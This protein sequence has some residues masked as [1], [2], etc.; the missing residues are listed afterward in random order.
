MAWGERLMM[1]LRIVHTTEFEYDGRATASYNQ[2]RLTP[3]TDADQIVSH[4]RLDVQ[5]TPW[6]YTYTDYFGTQITA[7]EVL[8]PHDSLQVTS[9]STVHTNRQELPDA[10][11]SWEEVADSSVSDRW[12]E[13]LAHSPV[14]APTDDLRE[15]CVQLRS[16]SARPGDAARALCALVY[17]K[18]EYRSGSTSVKSSG[19][20]AWEQRS[21]VCQ[22]MAHVVIGGLRT[23]GIPARYISGYL[24]P[25]REPEI[26]DTVRGESHA[27]VEWWDDG[28]HAFDPTNDKVPGD[29]YVVITAGRDYTDVKPLSGI[30]TGA[31]TERIQVDVHI[32]RLA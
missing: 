11:L 13:Y 24:H 17:A 14:V 12:T 10:V 5:P 28:W 25:K 6:T 22:D 3:L 15:R 20:E 21:G 1:Q 7:F 29:R 32:T 8:D 4:T 18:M 9:T 23:M 26:G 2:A 27:W 30:F 31:K 16:E 19:A